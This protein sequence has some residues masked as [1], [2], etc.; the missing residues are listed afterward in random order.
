MVRTRS[1]ETAETP[2]EV[3]LG[4]AEPVR[5]RRKYGVLLIMIA[6]R[7]MA[8]L[9]FCKSMSVLSLFAGSVGQL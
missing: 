2:S 5:W 1:L 4:N 6:V 7:E 9:S 3:H 8:V